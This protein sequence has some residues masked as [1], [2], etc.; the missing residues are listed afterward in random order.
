MD[1]DLNFTDKRGRLFTTTL[2]L[3][4]EAP[5]L[6]GL[7]LSLQG[8]YD[9]N[10][11]GTYDKETTY[12]LYDYYTDEI[13][14]T[15]GN[16]NYYGESVRENE[17]YYGRFQANYNWRKG[18]HRVAVMGAAEATKNNMRTLS[19]SR[20]FGDFYTHNT[21]SSGDPSTASA[22]G[23]RTETATAGY[24]GRINYDFA[25]KYLVELMGRYDATYLY[26][27]G[28]RWGFFPSYSLGWRISEEPFIKDNLPWVSML[29][30]RWSDGKT[31]LTQG[32]PY[33]YETGYSASSPYVFSP[34]SVAI[35]YANTEIVIQSLLGRIS[36]CSISVSIGTGKTSLAAHLISSRERPPELQEPAPVPYPLFWS[37]CSAGQCGFRLNVG[38]ELTLTHRN[39]IGAF[40]YN[41]ALT[42]TYTRMK[43]LHVES[44][45]TSLWPSMLH[46]TAPVCLVKEA[47][48]QMVKLPRA[49]V[50]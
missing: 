50:L 38:M 47:V 25:D 39:H 35:G 3:R 40:N 17:R 15:G 16:R 6:K 8:A 5:F 27:R 18:R 34:G 29:K 24:L 21:V 4:Y 23:T 37:Q 11:N 46:T 33:A 7:S 22:D 26:A 13:M 44:Q 43:N 42:G 14:G 28:H 1:H 9:F 2:N 32:A 12:P 20:Q 19:G 31:G 48:K 41:V 36:G 49:V 45:A 30:L 10:Y